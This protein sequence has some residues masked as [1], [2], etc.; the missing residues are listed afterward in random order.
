MNERQRI[1]A[2]ISELEKQ[3]CSTCAHYND[4]STKCDCAAAVKI[5]EL[6]QQLIDITANKRKSILAEKLKRIR[7]DGLTVEGYKELREMDL[8]NKQIIKALGVSE[9][10]F[11]EWK[12]SALG[13]Q[14]ARN[15]KSAKDFERAKWRGIAEKNGIKRK[16]FDLRISK[17]KSYEEAATMPLARTDAYSA[18]DAWTASMNGISKGTYLARV[19]SGWPS[20]HACRAPK[21]KRLEAWLKEQKAKA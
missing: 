12:S 2:Q 21:S 5:R 18:E 8:T 1:L 7:Q 19:R 14:P 3:R 20:E 16:T 11:Y 6:G 13:N 9:P 10:K 17:G 4:A 15:L